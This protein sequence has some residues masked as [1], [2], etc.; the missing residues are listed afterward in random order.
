MIVRADFE[1]TLINCCNA[2]FTHEKFF[3]RLNFYSSKYAIFGFF[4]IRSKKFRW[5]C[6]RPKPIQNC[7]L[8]LLLLNK[9]E[10]D[11]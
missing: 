10:Y 2:F 1:S 3:T 4:F 11:G 7:L 8:F 9:S 5:N 6:D